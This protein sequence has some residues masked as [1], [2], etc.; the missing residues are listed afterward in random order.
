MKKIV[1]RA[2][3]A[4]M[5]LMLAAI[6]LCFYLGKFAYAYELIL[7]LFFVFAGLGQLYKLRNDEYMFEREFKRQ[8][9]EIERDYL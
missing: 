9:S 4:L 7:V 6:V 3:V 8:Q 2:A 1:T 5:I